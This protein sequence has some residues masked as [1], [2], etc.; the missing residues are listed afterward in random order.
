MTKSTQMEDNFRKIDEL[1]ECRMDNKFAGGYAWFCKKCNFECN[2]SETKFECQN[3]KILPTY[4]KC[5]YGCGSQWKLEVN[6]C[7]EN[8]QS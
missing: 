6:P 4:I 2:V 8:Y 7:E 3:G 5:R 1:F